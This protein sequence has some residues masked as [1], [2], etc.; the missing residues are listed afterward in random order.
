M[1]ALAPVSAIYDL[2]YPCRTMAP[3]L[4]EDEM[5]S[6]FVGTM[7]MGKVRW[8]CFIQRT[9]IFMQTH[10]IVKNFSYQNESFFIFFGTFCLQKN[11]IHQIE[12]DEDRNMIKCLKV[13]KHPAEIGQLSPCPHDANLLFTVFREGHS[14]ARCP[15][16]VFICCLTC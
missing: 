15:L 7:M 5:H 2:K 6:F 8:K 14:L 13:L 12:F 9:E 10:D 4:A 16:H 3:V 1:L 11:E